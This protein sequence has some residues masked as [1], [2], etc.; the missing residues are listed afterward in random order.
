MDKY[1][2]NARIYPIV[3]LLLPIVILGIAYSIQFEQ[4]L[5]ILSTLGVSAALT[6]FMSQLGRDRGKNAE[7]TLWS[8]C[9][10]MPSVQLLRYSNNSI[11]SIRKDR[12]HNRMLELS[13]VEEGIDFKED[14]ELEHLNEIYRAWSK[15]LITKTRDTKQFSLIFKENISYGFRRNIWGLKP[16]AI[17]IIL[18]SLVANYLFQAV[19]IG[20]SNFSL[21]PAEFHASEILLIIL[22]IL[23]VFVITSDWIKIPAFAYATRLFEAIDSF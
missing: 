12:Y 10:G 23:W 22:L 15:Y 4:Y 20:Y 7:L 6:Y 1:S 19:T 3:I 2:V 11:D 14:D 9:G 16:I 13:P 17:P 8:K 21:F 5:Q 18:I